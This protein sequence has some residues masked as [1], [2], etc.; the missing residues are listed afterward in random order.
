[1]S[2]LKRVTG[3]LLE[4]HLTEKDFARVWVNG[5]AHRHL[6][7]CLEC[8]VRYDAFAAS[9]A[10]IAGDLRD[11]ADSAFPAERLAAQQAQVLRR[12]EALERPVRIIA[13]PRAARPV[14]AGQSHVRR[15]ITAA[16]AAG[17][18]VGVGI[19]QLLEW[20]HTLTID[21]RPVA[22]TADTHAVKPT[23]ATRG[24]GV[25]ALP[26]GITDEDLLMGSE[27]LARPR[28]A[29]LGALD[30]LTPHVRDVS[31]ERPR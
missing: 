13:F 27:A 23:A 5:G 11:E 2:V 31:P 17:L 29:A 24:S 20:R 9:L 25:R 18:I 4:G 7:G 30:D 19:G 3:R 6:D 1:V 8:R 26:A 16:A 28:V 15:W 21:R 10:V 12:L 14:I 22:M